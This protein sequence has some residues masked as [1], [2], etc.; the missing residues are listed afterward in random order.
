MA[1]MYASNA[2]RMEKPSTVSDRRPPRPPSA[3]STP[4]GRSNRSW[5]DLDDEDQFELSD[6]WQNCSSSELDTS[7]FSGCVTSS[8]GSL[9]STHRG[10]GAKQKV[11]KLCNRSL[12]RDSA[13]SGSGTNNSTDEPQGQSDQSQF[14]SFDDGTSSAGESSPS[15]AG[16]GMEDGAGTQ[17]QCAEG[18]PSVGSMKHENGTCRVCLFVNTLIGCNK[19]LACEFCHL[20]HKRSDGRPR[21]C[22]GKRERYKKLVEMKMG[23]NESPE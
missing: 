20:Q 2:S 13:S 17:A 9:S 12:G 21:A 15:G 16:S 6:T 5:A 8:D 4:S 22:K 1:A 18:F 23:Q 10:P 3:P 11:K 14:V 19:G 7:V